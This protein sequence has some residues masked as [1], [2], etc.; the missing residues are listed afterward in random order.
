H[1]PRSTFSDK[2]M[3]IILWSHR[4]MGVPVPST[5]SMKRVQEVLQK[6]CGIR[7]SRYRGAFGNIY[8]VND[9]HGMIAQEFANPR[10]PP[11]LHFLPDE[12]RFFVCVERALDWL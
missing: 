10:V 8:Y 9:F 11:H 3:N 1:L 7:T 12:E 2:Q 5:C 6:L 4:C